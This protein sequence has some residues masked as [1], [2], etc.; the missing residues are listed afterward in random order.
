M[1]NKIKKGLNDLYERIEQRVY[2]M[3]VR[4]EL[5]KAKKLLAEIDKN[6]MAE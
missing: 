2:K 3:R 1:V 6:R 4:Q 5:R